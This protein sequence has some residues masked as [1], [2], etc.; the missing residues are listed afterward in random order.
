MQDKPTV[1]TAYTHIQLTKGKLQIK[2]ISVQLQLFI[3]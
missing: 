3:A 1:S 2:D